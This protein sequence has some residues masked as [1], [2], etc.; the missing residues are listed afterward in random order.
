MS[1]ALQIDM[2]PTQG[3]LPALARRHARRRCRCTLVSFA[4]KINVQNGHLDAHVLVPQD[5]VLVKPIGQEA[6][7]VPDGPNHA[8]SGLLLDESIAGLQTV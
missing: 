1:H 4:R 3:P 7:H 2:I 8:T 6:I 5:K